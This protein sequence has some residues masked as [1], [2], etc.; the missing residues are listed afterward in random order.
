MKDLQQDTEANSNSII[1]TLKHYLNIRIQIVRLNITEKIA[2]G[3][4]GV[5]TGAAMAITYLLAFTFASFALCYWLGKLLKSTESGFLCCAAIYA[6][7]GLI[8]HFISKT[9]LNRILT[10][11]F[12]DDLTKDEDDK[13]FEEE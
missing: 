9:R 11:K 1:H 6:C 3:L 4:S 5:I 13:E 8:I 10:D 2:T 7:I 12:I